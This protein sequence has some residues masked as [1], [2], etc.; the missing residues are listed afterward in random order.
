MTDSIKSSIGSSAEFRN[1]HLVHSNEASITVPIRIVSQAMPYMRSPPRQSRALPR[2]LS[3]SSQS[4]MHVSRGQQ[5]S[6]RLPSIQDILPN[7]PRQGDDRSLSELRSPLR[8]TPQG[9]S[10]SVDIPAHLSPPHVSDRTRS[11]LTTSA[12]SQSGRIRQIENGNSRQPSYDAPPPY[13]LAM[14]S[15]P[16]RNGCSASNS[17]APPSPYVNEP[18][19]RRVYQST[20]PHSSFQ[21]RQGE[22]SGLPPPPPPYYN[23]YNTLNGHSSSYDTARGYSNDESHRGDVYYSTSRLGTPQYHSSSSTYA[24]ASY[25]YQVSSNYSGHY[26]SQN[27]H[28]YQN[29]Y[30]RPMQFESEDMTSQVPKKRRGNLPRDVTD[31]L[32]QWF[33]E[34]I[35]HPYP[36]EE[37]K[38]MLCRRTGLAM[39]QISNWFI[40][41]RR[42][43]T[44][45]L[46]QQAN[47]EKKLRERSGDT[48]SSSD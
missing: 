30:H 31:M 25:G 4:S 21:S 8:H 46:T 42:R 16:P 19:S 3:L 28:Q 10:R 48:S 7:I 38:Q 22:S 1:S 43:R 34:H 36:T 26:A 37:E 27:G 17:P 2:E 11:S 41:S 15:G 35:A 29:G 39:T 44:P 23:Q 45:E 40:N 20:A 12:L 5:I 18:D 32:K 47:A 13:P 24:S 6:E 9:P 33:E 14:H